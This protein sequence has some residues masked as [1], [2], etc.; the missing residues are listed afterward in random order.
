[1]SRGLIHLIGAPADEGKHGHSS[2]FLKHVTCLRCL[3][4]RAGMWHGKHINNSGEPP[5]SRRLL[6]RGFLVLRKDLRSA[7]KSAMEKAQAA[8]TLASLIT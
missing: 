4:W 7:N 2:R 1:M 3:A 5:K 6:A 8:I